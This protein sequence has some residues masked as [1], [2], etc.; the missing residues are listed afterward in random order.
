MKTTT[1]PKPG[2]IQSPFLKIK[3]GGAAA[4]LRV[5]AS[6]APLYFEHRVEPQM[7]TLVV[8]FTDRAIGSVKKN[9]YPFH[10]LK[11]RVRQTSITSV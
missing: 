6:S 11:L 5:R 7:Y 1:G 3:G 8:F 4:E 10:R 2:P 9:G